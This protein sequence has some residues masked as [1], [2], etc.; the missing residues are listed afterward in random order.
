MNVIWYTGFSKDI[1]STKRPSTESQ[2]TSDC[3]IFEPC[4]I[5]N[6]SFIIGPAGGDN[7]YKNVTYCY[8]PNWQRY[9]WITDR[10]Y[11]DGR[12]IIDASID[13]LATYKTEIGLTTQFVVRSGS[14]SNDKITDTAYPLNGDITDTVLS[15]SNVSPPFTDTI[16]SGSFIVGIVGEA[17]ANVAAFGAVNY[18]E[19]SLSEFSAFITKLMSN[20]GD[21]LDVQ[22]SDLSDSTTKMILNPMQYITSCKWFPLSAGGSA[23]SGDIKFG[24]WNISGVAHK[25]PPTSGGYPK[26]SQLVGF[27][28]ASVRHPQAATRGQYMNRAPY[29]T[30]RLY[31]PQVGYIEIP[32]DIYDES[33][34]IAVECK[35]DLASGQMVMDIYARDTELTPTNTWHIARSTVQIGID[36]PIAQIATDIVGTAQAGIGA[37]TS[38]ISGGV[39]GFGSGGVVGAIV[40]AVGGL[41]G[42]AID[43]AVKAATPIANIMPSTGSLAGYFQQPEIICSFKHVCDDVPTII[44]KPLCAPAQINTLSGFTQCATNHIAIKNATREE[45]TQIETYMK[46]GFYYE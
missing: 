35:V 1:N 30:Y 43:T 25:K 46:E 6:P 42:G 29:S 45:L 9:Y 27:N 8:V 31:M 2:F 37:I 44:G 34:Y 41:L 3:Q 14:S 20:D 28:T 33:G 40:G 5:L 23:A 17:D 13:V 10:R 4:S 22:H 36:V 26:T 16:S 32:S 24:W 38:G 19:F 15:Y 11:Y 12:F 39:S 7:I 21:W 18:Y